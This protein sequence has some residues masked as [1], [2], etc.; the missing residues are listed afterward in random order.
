M[1]CAPRKNGPGPSIS[2]SAPQ[3]GTARD[4]LVGVTDTGQS[5]VKTGAAS[6]LV[7]VHVSGDGARMWDLRATVNGSPE[8]VEA[9]SGREIYA[10]ADGA[11]FVSR[12]G[13]HTFVSLTRWGAF[14]RRLYA[15]LHSCQ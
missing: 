9:A 13:G 3:I 10:A 5:A 11:A 4:L 7:V 12:D 14:R 1:R 2:P 6:H 8:A 15:A